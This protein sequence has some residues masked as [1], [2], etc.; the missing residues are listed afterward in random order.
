[1]ILKFEQGETIKLKINNRWKNFKVFEIKCDDWIVFEGADGLK[2]T[3]S[4]AIHA[5]H[6]KKTPVKT[7]VKTK[8]KTK[9]KTKTKSKKKAK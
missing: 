7:K 6:I 8:T 5:N 4:P 1:M 3:L 9:V 2:V